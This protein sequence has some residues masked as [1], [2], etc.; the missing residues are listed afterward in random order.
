MGLCH[1]VR[2]I[3]QTESG[4]RRFEHLSSAVEDELAVDSHPQFTVAFFELPG[5]QAAI[6]RQAQIDAVVLCQVLRLLRRGSLRE[7]RRRADDRHTDVRRSEEHTSELQ[8]PM[9]LVCRLL[10]E[11]KT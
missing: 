10:L 3:G 1:V 4:Q 6:S 9:Y 7:I 11:K 5:V 2:D 8:S